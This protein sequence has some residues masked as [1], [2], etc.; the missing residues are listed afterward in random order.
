ME[1]WNHAMNFA[2][3]PVQ[4]WWWHC[5]MTAR[6]HMKNQQ[7]AG[8]FGIKEEKIT[9]KAFAVESYTCITR[10]AAITQPPPPHSC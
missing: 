9:A 4:A 1:N 5:F 6:G 7:Q 2:T 10:E 3:V 8:C